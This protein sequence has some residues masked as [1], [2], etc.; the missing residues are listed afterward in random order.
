MENSCVFRLLT[1]HDY[2]PF[3]KL[4]S[5]FRPTIFTYEQF[6]ETLACISLSSEI[7]V[8]EQ[9][10][11]LVATGTLIYETKYIFNICTLAHIEDVCVAE[12]ERGKGLGKWLMARMVEVAQSK[13]C[14]KVTLDCAE[15]NVAFYTKCGF[16]QR[17]HQMTVFFGMT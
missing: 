15:S 2:A 8:L 3:L 6:C 5:Q 4:I 11:A 16:E 1:V 7:Y 12:T 9:E 10:G 13:G 14:Y 17:G